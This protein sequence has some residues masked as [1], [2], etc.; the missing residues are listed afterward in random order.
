MKK[1][2][3]YGAGN[4]GRGFIGKAFSESGYEVCFVDVAED[5]VE[6]LNEDKS[7]P[8]RIVSNDTDSIAIV[9]NARAINGKYI[10]SVAMEITGADIMATA[11]GVNAL[12]HIIKPLCQGLRKR[13]EEGGKA[14]NIIICE[15][16][17]DADKFMRKMIEQELGPSY[18]AALDEKLGLVE[19]SIGRMVPVMTDEMKEGNMLTVWVEPYDELPVDKAAFK[20]DIPEIKGL[21]PFSPFGFYIKRKLYIHNMSHAMCAYLGWR[22]GYS[23]IYECINDN[24]I[25]SQTCAAMTQAAKALHNEYGVPL[26]ELCAHIEELSARFG[27]VALS[28]TVDR[29]GRDP[30]RKLRNNDR[31]IGAALYCMSQGY[32]PSDLTDGIIAALHYDNPED[33]AASRMQHMIREQGV[34]A[35]LTTHCGLDEDSPLLKKVLAQLATQIIKLF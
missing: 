14:L 31:L 11:V 29:V 25:K 30:L 23:Y 26:E 21:V 13:F 16:L 35:F 6:K 22:K 20:G 34:K 17:I 7:Y 2:V 9:K 18:K 32:S 5:V 1:A 27:N 8:V 4:I 12:P 24:N 19:A 15:N 10:D 3:M 33:E 28:D